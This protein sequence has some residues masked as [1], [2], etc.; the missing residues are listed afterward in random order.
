MIGSPAARLLYAVWA[1][2]TVDMHLDDPAERI[3]TAAAAAAH[4][5]VRSFARVSVTVV[6]PVERAGLVLRLAEFLPP[7]RIGCPSVS[8]G[9]AAPQGIGPT[10]DQ[11][12]AG[13]QVRAGRSAVTLDPGAPLVPDEERAVALG[14]SGTNDRAQSV[15]RLVSLCRRRPS[16]WDGTLGLGEIPFDVVVAGADTTPPTTGP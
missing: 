14:I 10:P 5:A 9:I 4:L 16:S 11:P 7:D 15:L 8:G 3:E 6:D 13:V 2:E 1:D 12:A